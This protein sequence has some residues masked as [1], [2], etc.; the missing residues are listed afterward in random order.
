MVASA[1]RVWVY[2]NG[3]LSNYISRN[4]E[5]DLNQVNVIREIYVEGR[6]PQEL[7]LAEESKAKDQQ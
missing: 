2:L 1:C 7:L 6:Q 5:I 4:T 3:I